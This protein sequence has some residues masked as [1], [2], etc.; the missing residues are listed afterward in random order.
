MNAM[1]EL[2]ALYNEYFDRL[3]QNA[4]RL[5]DFYPE[6]AEFPLRRK[7]REEFEEFMSSGVK[8]ESKRLWLRRVL[9]GRDELLPLLPE[10]VQSLARRAA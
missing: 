5:N 4:R 1:D 7:S 10:H 2:F 3:E 8:S 6:P 9:N